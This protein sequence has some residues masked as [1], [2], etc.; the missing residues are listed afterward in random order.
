MGYDELKP[1]S[2]VGSNAFGGLGATAIDSLDTLWMLGLKDEFARARAWVADKLSFDRYASAR[3]LPCFAHNGACQ[4]GAS[5]C[6][7]YDA[8]VFETTIR[9]LGGLLSAYDLS[10]DRVFL[11]R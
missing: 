1:Q 7:D 8:S 4:G 11:T 6:R 2:R 10:G 5:A 9:I 3:R